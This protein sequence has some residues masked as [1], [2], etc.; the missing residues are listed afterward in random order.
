MAYDYE[1]T[2]KAKEDIDRALEYIAVKLSNIKAA[3]NL[4]IEIEETIEK[5][6]RYPLSY[7]DCSYFYI[8][9]TSYRHAIINNYTLVYRISNDK[10]IIIRLKHSKQNK[11]L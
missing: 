2:D 9:D 10:I 4:F 7:P 6:C 1:I 8:K 5:I 11:V 3:S